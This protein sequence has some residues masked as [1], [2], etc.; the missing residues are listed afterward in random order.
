MPSGVPGEVHDEAG[1]LAARAYHLAPLRGSRH[2]AQLPRDVVRRASAP[3]RHL[4]V[5]GAG[6]RRPRHHDHLHPGVVESFRQHAHVHHVLQASGLEVREHP[7]P[8]V[9][10][11][12]PAYPRRLVGLVAVDD[13]RQ[14]FRLFDR[15]GEDYRAPVPADLHRR[16]GHALQVPLAFHHLREV[17]LVQVSRRG[18][19]AGEVERADRD[20]LLLDG[21]E[22]SVVD[23]V[24]DA[25]LVGHAL[26]HL[27]ER[28]LVR[29]VGRRG[30]AENL[31]VRVLPVPVDAPAV[32][33]SRRVVRLVDHDEPEVLRVELAHAPRAVAAR[34]MRLHGGHHHGRHLAEIRLHMV[35]AHFDLRFKPGDAVDLVGGLRNQ[36]LAV[37]KHH[38]PDAPSMHLPYDVCEKHRL[39]KARGQDHERGCVVLPL[40]EHALGRRFLVVA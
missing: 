28:C 15:R 22:P 26:E 36:L 16:H 6:F 25:V 29:T 32:R 27:A 13:L 34:A 5:Q 18:A 7:A 11:R 1:R 35:L 39:S 19:Y 31:A 20:H 23:R 33:A 38:R 21:D 9:L 8:V 37:R 14:T 17:A 24:E 3:A 30:H 2:V 40:A 4:R 12:L 10:V